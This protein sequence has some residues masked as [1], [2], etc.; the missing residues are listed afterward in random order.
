MLRPRVVPVPCLRD[1]YAYLVHR[2]GE[3]ACV[4]V[5]PSEAAPVEAALAREG[6]T[7]R[8]LLATHHHLDHVGGIQALADRFAGI[9]VVASRVDGARIAGVT[10]LVD[11]GEHLAIA[12][13]AVA[14]LAVPGHTLGAVA[15]AIG[16]A[17]F[18]GDT[19]FVGGCGRLFEG[20]AAQLHASLTERLGRLD[21]ATRVYCGH[22]YT[23][24]NARFA[25][26]LDPGCEPAKSLLDRAIEAAARGEPTVPSTIADE[27][28]HNPFLR[29][30][31]PAHVARFGERDPVRALAALR[32][33]K[34]A[35]RAP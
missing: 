6:L 31:A 33:A 19:L 12:G 9:E 22:E 16:D 1:N 15:F 27:L 29:P 28:A 5:D 14:A 10:R 4:V 3:A 26:H 32:A 23:L 7:P 24:A 8:A 25:L 18:T 20:T 35:Y 17:V 34:D 2:E 13:L 11:D 30:L 21:P